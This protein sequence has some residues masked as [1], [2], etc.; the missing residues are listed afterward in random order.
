MTLTLE[1][2]FDLAAQLVTVKFAAIF[3]KAGAPYVLHLFTVSAR[4]KRLFD[5]VVALLHD[6]VEDTDITCEDLL[7]MGFWPD[8]VA[9]VDAISKRPHETSDA[10]FVRVMANESATR[11]K[12]HDTGHNGE[13]D[14]FAD[15]TAENY[16]NCARYRLK[17]R[18]LTEH[19]LERDWIDIEES[20]V[21]Y[22]VL[23]GAGMGHK[24]VWCSTCEGERLRRSS[25]WRGPKNLL[26]ESLTNG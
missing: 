10:Y 13:V 11:V 6:V 3:D 9:A 14:R 18:M 25:K 20:F 16:A 12:I 15:P 1:Q 8:I 7:A 17:N 19:A 4:C 22:C 26:Q 5:K 23:C 24:A 21:A 2:Q